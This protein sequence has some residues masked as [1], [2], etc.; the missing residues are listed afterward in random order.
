MADRLYNFLLRHPILA[1]ITILAIVVSS[2]YGLKNTRIISDFEV[3]FEKHNPHLVAY[4]ELQDNYTRSD[5]VYFIVVPDNGNVFTQNAMKAAKELTEKAWQLPYSIRVDSLTNYQH[6]VAENDDLIVSDLIP[7]PETITIEQLQYAREVALNEPYLNGRLVG[8]SEVATGVNVMFQ[9]PH[10]NP[11]D[12]V[13]EVVAAVKQLRQ[14]IEASH[15]VE[16]KLSGKLMNNNAFKELSMKDLSTLVP[17]AF[18]IAFIMIAIYIYYASKSI[19]T[20]IS[21]TFAVFLVVIFSVLTGQGLGTW[22]GIEISPPVANAPTIILTL[23]IAD[24]L[25]ILVNFFQGL[26]KGLDKKQAMKESLLL[27]NQP[28]L[29]TSVTTVIGFLSLNFSDSPPFKDLGNVVAIGVTCAWFFSVTFL[30]ALIILLPIRVNQA[31]EQENISFMDKLAVWTI[32][33]HKILLAAT[34]SL[35]VL[36]TAFIPQNRLNDVWSHYFDEKVEHRQDGMF[37]KEHITT[38]NTIDFSLYTGGD[39]TISDPDFLNTVDQFVNWLEQHPHVFHV[40]AI[41]QVMKRLN[42]NMH[43]DD[44]TWYRLPE[45]AELASQYLLLYEMSLPF[46]LD[47]NNQITMDKQHTRVSVVVRD[48]DTGKILQLQKDAAYWLKHN[49]PDYMLTEGSSSDVMF[50]HMSRNNATSMLTGTFSA[51][52]LISLLLTMALRSLKFGLLSL[53]TNIIPAAVAFGIWGMIDGEVGI[54]LSVVAGMSLGIVVDYTVHLLSKYLRAK[55]EQQLNTEEAVRYAF[56]TVGV[57][58]FV[59]TLVLVANFGILALSQFALNANMGFMT[60]ITIISALVIDFFFLP[61]LLII[62]GGK[63][64]TDKAP[65]S[66]MVEAKPIIQP[67]SI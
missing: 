66:D 67:G 62:L 43:G 34:I 10:I 9:L 57:A 52:L 5:N 47:L 16:I 55:R 33:H 42:K 41:T 39:R 35:I 45:N 56:N 37:L 12:E 7:D 17:I 24:S 59:T 50:A 26:H 38:N 4:H 6:T 25:H 28:V 31:S 23:A 64:Q 13:P 21:A 30:P 20:L 2:A 53:L 27:N 15:P 48:S 54:S 40:N 1:I 61:P 60:A 58:L 3:F 22:L 63:K 46:G 19:I 36:I 11:N 14:Q 65:D 49:A 44:P 51:L 29:L 18:V 8:P 32:Q